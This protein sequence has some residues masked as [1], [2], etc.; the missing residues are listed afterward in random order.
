[1]IYARRLPSY[2]RNLQCSIRFLSGNHLNAA[3]EIGFMKPCATVHC[4]EVN[5]W[6]EVHAKQQPLLI[7]GIASKWPAVGNVDASRSWASLGYMKAA[8]GQSKVPVEVGGDYMDPDTK[9]HENVV[10]FYLKLK[11]ILKQLCWAEYRCVQKMC[12]PEKNGGP[13]KQ[14]VAV[15]KTTYSYYITR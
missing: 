14:H 10:V 1:M 4:D 13:P 2:G 12:T 8:F 15:V 9:Y 3:N 11:Y 7:R 5:D 6:D